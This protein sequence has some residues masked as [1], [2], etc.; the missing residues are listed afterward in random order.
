[1]CPGSAADDA[2]T[3]VRDALVADAKKELLLKKEWFGLL[4]PDT[5]IRQLYDAVQLFILLYLFWVLP[6]RIAFLKSPKGWEALGDVAIDGTVWLDIL[7][8]MNM[9]YYDTKTKKLITDKY[10]IISANNKLQYH[11]A[12]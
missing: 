3:Q 8:S 5:P 1:M 6:N 4:H 7:L 9:Y 2:T 11:Q 12:I 10:Q